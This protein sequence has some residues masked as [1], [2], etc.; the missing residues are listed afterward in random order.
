MAARTGGGQ[1][2]RRPAGAGTAGGGDGRGERAVAESTGEGRLPQGGVLR[3]YIAGRR[4][5]GARDAVIYNFLSS[6]D[7]V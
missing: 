5:S 1:G 7:H 6:D 3:R 2:V 4:G